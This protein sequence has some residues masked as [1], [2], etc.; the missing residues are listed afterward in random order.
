MQELL[1]PSTFS[2]SLMC[3][4]LQPVSSLLRSD[5]CWYESSRL[6][7]FLRTFGLAETQ[8]EAVFPISAPPSAGGLGEGRG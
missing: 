5:S 4:R 2:R 1:L 6:W 7:A 8:Q 3:C